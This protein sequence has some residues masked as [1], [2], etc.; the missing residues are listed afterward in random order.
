MKEGFPLCLVW[1]LC[2]V[3]F[4]VCVV[5]FVGLLLWSF[6][7]VLFLFA[8]GFFLVFVSVWGGFFTIV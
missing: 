4:C 2:L 5:L 8:W 7:Q 1:I 6:F 3:G